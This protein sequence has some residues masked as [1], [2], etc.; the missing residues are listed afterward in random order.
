MSENQDFALNDEGPRPG[1][2]P[3]EGAAPPPLVVIEYRRGISSVLAP[4]GL[5]L[6]IC[7]AILSYQRQTP[8]R[9]IATAPVAAPPGTAGGPKGQGR[10]I[11]VEPSNTGAAFAPIAARFGAPPTHPPEPDP[12][13]KPETESVESAT[14]G[15]EP[16]PAREIRVEPPAPE[17]AR[18][19]QPPDPPRVAHAEPEAPRP[20]LAENLEEIRRE[21]ERK[22]ADLEEMESIKVESRGVLIYEAFQKA[23]ANRPAFRRELQRV[24]KALGKQGGPE[25]EKLC[26]RYGRT[27]VQEIHDRVLR[28]LNRNAMPL[29]NPA[30][31]EMMRRRGLPEPMILDYLAHQ[32]RHTINTRGGPRDSHEVRVKAA[33]QLLTVPLAPDLAPTPARGPAPPSGPSRGGRPLTV[34]GPAPA[35]PGRQA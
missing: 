25:I 26:E 28:D 20:T 22:A 19:T 5:I 15:T 17:P 7:L 34:P 35:R 13:I 29:S 3:A 6:L 23:Q 21:A 10:I 18:A 11:M 31:V 2:S 16:T 4:P 1:P 14:P 12:A 27:T 9:P 32:L 33:Q 8:I 30:R 24:L